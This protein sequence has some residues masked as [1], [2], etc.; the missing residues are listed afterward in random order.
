M[1]SAAAKLRSLYFRYRLRQTAVASDLKLRVTGVT[2]LDAA[3]AGAPLL[4]RQTAM[5]WIGT[6][7][8]ERWLIYPGA[9]AEMA[10]PKTIETNDAGG[11]HAWRSIYRLPAYVYRIP[12]GLYHGE[13]GAAVDYQGC[14]FSDAVDAMPDQF[15]NLS[16]GDILPSKSQP[17]FCDGDA[18]ALSSSKNYYH[19][20]IKMVPR[21]HLVAQAGIDIA[22]CEAILINQPTAAQREGYVEA[23]LRAEAL[24]IVKSRHFWFCRNLY[25]PTVAHDVPPWAI[26][27]LRRTF[28]RLMRGGSSGP[29]AVYLR[30]GT[31]RTRSVLNEE[32]VCEYLA[33]C[34]VEAFQMNERSLAEQIGILAHADLIIAPHGA[35]LSNLAF[36]KGSARCLEILADSDAQK[37]YWI[38]AQHLRMNYHYFVAEKV[39]R[40]DGSEDF[41]MVIPIEKLKRAL[42]FLLRDYSEA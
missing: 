15:L 31:T 21:L 20:L 28:A 4:A 12:Q 27:Y 22:R 16:P 41:D 25:L 10:L 40:T 18:I 5:R 34:G 35:A 33:T 7:I 37:C 8:P 39:Y 1:R 9:A 19:W 2:S 42:D 23:G 38:L 30:R 24:K 32:E 3:F 29:R 36:A 26:D 17:H 11:F 6:K 13:H 14:V